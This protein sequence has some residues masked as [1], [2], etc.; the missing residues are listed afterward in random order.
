MVVQNQSQLGEGSAIPTDPHHTHTF[1]QPSTQPQK[2]QQPTK[3]KRKDT[4]IKIKNEGW[5]IDPLISQKK[6]LL[7]TGNGD[8]LAEDCSRSGLLIGLRRSWYELVFGLR[9]SW[10]ELVFGLRRSWYRSSSALHSIL[11]PSTESRKNATTAMSGYET[12]Y[13]PIVVKA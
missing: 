12:L 9:R 4:Q 6:V 3:P 8:Y 2:T 10:Y 5:D 13:R 11:R 1:I 7:N